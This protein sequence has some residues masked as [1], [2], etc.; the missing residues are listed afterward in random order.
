MNGY[1]Q[2]ARDLM[3]QLNTLERA[4]A[5][6]DPQAAQA[7]GAAIEAYLT[8]IRLQVVGRAGVGRTSVAAIVDK[9]GS[10]IS[11]GRYGHPNPIQRVVAVAECGAVDAPGG[12]EPQIDADM[13]VY[14][15]VD[16][17]RDADRAMLADIDSVVAVLNKADTLEDPQARAQS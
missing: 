9:L 8:P 4:V 15:L 14:V 11:G 3:E 13:V 17:P 7:V 5:A 1:D 12:Q 6:V 2:Q 16:P 10:V